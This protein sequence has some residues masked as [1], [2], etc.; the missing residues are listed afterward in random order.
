MID[1]IVTVP[2]YLV[3]RIFRHEFQRSSNNKIAML[4]AVRQ[5]IG[6]GA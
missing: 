5:F 6:A 1:P 4:E 3:L 2:D